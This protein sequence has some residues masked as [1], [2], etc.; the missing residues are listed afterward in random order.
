MTGLNLW[1]LSVGVAILAILAVAA[2]SHLLEKLFD[3]VHQK[4]WREPIWGSIVI[5][6]RQSKELF[7]SLGAALVA[8]S[9]IFWLAKQVFNVLNQ[10]V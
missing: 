6:V 7:I 4:R 2:V 9:L 5:F 1:I 8:L 10:H 3:K